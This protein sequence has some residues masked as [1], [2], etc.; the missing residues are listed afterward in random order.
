MLFFFSSLRLFGDTGLGT[1]LILR[2]VRQAQT[3]VRSACL[4]KTIVVLCEEHLVMEVHTLLPAYANALYYANQDTDKELKGI[5]MDVFELVGR[6]TFPEVYVHYILP[7]LRG[8]SDVVQFGTDAPMRV[9][10]MQLLQALISG[11]RPSQLLAHFTDLAV[12]L[13]DPFVIDSESTPLQEAAADVLLTLLECLQGK[14]KAAVEAHFLNT[15]RLTSLR[16]AT[17][18][19]FRFFL[20]TLTSPVPSLSS[21]GSRGLVLL[22]EF[23]TSPVGGVGSLF[24]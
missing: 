7:R 2:T 9:A 6:Y 12:T 1:N 20:E 15:G 3:R 24:R 17:N 19:L 10:V 23:E 4:L 16:T 22:A 14:G 11:S 8:D 21:K 13:T 18:K 5:L